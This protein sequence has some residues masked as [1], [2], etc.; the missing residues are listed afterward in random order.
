MREGSSR[1]LAREV[2]KFLSPPFPG[3]SIIF[4]FLDRAS[5]LAFLGEQTAL[6]VVCVDC[7]VSSGEDRFTGCVGGIEGMF[8]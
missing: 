4:C 1:G 2:L 8:L 6:V 3:V 5:V 7:T